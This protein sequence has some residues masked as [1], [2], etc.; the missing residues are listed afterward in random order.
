MRGAP[1]GAPYHFRVSSRYALLIAPSANRVYAD[2]APG[3][4]RAELAIFG[5]SVLS[6]PLSGVA[7]ARYGGVPYVVFE[8]ALTEA[9]VA[10]L[11]NLSSIYAL[12]EVVGADLLRPVS[13]SP[14]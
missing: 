14:L 3:L 2:A 13:L 6:A 9:D 1:R 7:E 11:S 8:A 5:S 10:Y 12:F 4:T